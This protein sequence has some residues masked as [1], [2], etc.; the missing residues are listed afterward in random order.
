MTK[1]QAEKKEQAGMY[2]TVAATT[3]GFYRAGRPWSRQ[4]ETVAKADFT[5]EQLEALENDKNIILGI[6]VAPDADLDEDEEAEQAK[7]GK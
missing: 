1:K 3:D 5:D 4:P 2:I 7:Q 6:G